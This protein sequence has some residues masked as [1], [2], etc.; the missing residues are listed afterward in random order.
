MDREQEAWEELRRSRVSPAARWALAL[1]FPLVIGVVFLLDLAEPHGP[2]DAARAFAERNRPPAAGTA[3][4][5]RMLAAWN[6]EALADIDAFEG[7]IADES[8]LRAAVPAYQWIFLRAFHTSGTGRVLVGRDDWFFLKEALETT[9]G[10]AAEANRRR[11][12]RAVRDLAAALEARGAEL[13]LVPVPG[14]ARVQP[15]RFSRRFDRGEVLPA[16]A[17]ADSL[18]GGWEGLPNVGVVRIADLLESR[19][20]EGGDSFLRR[21]THWTPGAMRAAV[22]AIV[23]AIGP[24]GGAGTPV[25]GGTRMVAGEGDLLRMIDLPGDPYPEQEVAVARPADA[26]P[27]EAD[28]RPARVIFLGDSFA[29]VYSDEALGWGTGAGLR[30][31]LPAM[32]RE[33]VR[34]FLNYGDPVLGPRRRLARLLAGGEFPEGG[35]VVVVW[36]FAER[37]LD[38]GDWAEVS[39]DAPGE[40]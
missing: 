25:P 29:A 12:D 3:G 40:L 11:A 13:L 14:K 1:G 5:W 6:E 8:V 31:W 26:D 28:E 34:F 36:Q 10:W 20:R 33:P 32:L 27:A 35:R 4:P 7:Q 22:D 37:F 39:F 9:L 16:G 18:Y 2:R 19:T 15:D 17:G 24:E 23:R 21:D 30:E 38:H